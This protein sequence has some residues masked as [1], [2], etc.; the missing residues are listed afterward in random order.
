MEGTSCQLEPLFCSLRNMLLR[1][2]LL[3]ALFH[4]AFW[5]LYVWMKI[6]L[7]MSVFPKWH[8]TPN[9]ELDTT[10][11]MFLMDIRLCYNSFFNH[12]IATEYWYLPMKMSLRNK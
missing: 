1:S 3:A 10:C 4:N 8:T 6:T 7:D 12:K 5:L 2:I 11:E 9:Y